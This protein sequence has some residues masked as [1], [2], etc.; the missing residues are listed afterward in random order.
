MICAVYKSRK[1]TGA[2]LFVE[3]RDDFSR[4]PAALRELLGPPQFLMLLRLDTG[5]PLAFSDTAT[6]M[7]ALKAQGFYLQLPPPEENL[8]DAHKRRQGGGS[9]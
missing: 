6:L 9:T 7:A 1:K 5:R 8:L 2:Y 4:V 3:R